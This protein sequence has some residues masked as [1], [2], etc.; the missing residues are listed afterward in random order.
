MKTLMKITALSIAMSMLAGCEKDENQIFYESGTEPVLSASTTTPILK[1]EPA[2]D[3][4]NVMT[5]SWTNPDYKFTTGISSHDVNY[6]LEFDTVGSNFNNPRKGVV[7]VA[8]NLSKTFTT[9]EMNALLSGLNQMALTPD[10]DYNMEARVVSYVGTNSLQLTSNKVSFKVRPFS[11]P[12]VV[13]VPDAGTLW[14][15]GD[16]FA[17]GWNNPLP[18]PYNTTQRFTRVSNT[19]YELVS[20]MPG[21]GGYKLIQEPGVWGTQYKMITGGGW[22]GGDFEKKDADPAFPGP[23]AAGKYKITFNF[24]SGKYTVA[25]Q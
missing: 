1:P 17:S 13:P 14:A 25:K 3:K 2:F 19:L 15:T 20:T 23:P 24:Q 18:A 12:P 5:F 6:R 22:D 21:G 11:P 4:D 9:G 16:A 8:K 10:R 7:V